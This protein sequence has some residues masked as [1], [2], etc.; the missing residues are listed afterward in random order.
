MTMSETRTKGGLHPPSVIPQ[1][2]QSISP[3][4]PLVE[5]TSSVQE[6]RQQ[7]NSSENVKGVFRLSPNYRGARLNG[8]EV[9]KY[10]LVAPMFPQD[11]FTLMRPLAPL[12]EPPDE[13]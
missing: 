8:Q 11:D 6:A 3:F 7:K 13:S 1:F 5:V 2:N 12:E 10:V 9:H 4:G